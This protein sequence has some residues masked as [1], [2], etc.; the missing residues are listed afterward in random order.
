MPAFCPAIIIA[1]SSYRFLSVVCSSSN[2]QLCC[3]VPFIYLMWLEEMNSDNKQQTIE[4]R[5]PIMPLP[6]P[7]SCILQHHHYY[8]HVPSYRVSDK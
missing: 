6:C 7:Y 1:I 8:R 3:F 5:I 2:L 4:S